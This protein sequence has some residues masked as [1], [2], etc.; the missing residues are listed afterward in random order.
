MFYKTI[1]SLNPSLTLDY[2]SNPSILESNTNPKESLNTHIANTLKTNT[3]IISNNI[4][5]LRINRANNTSNPNPLSNTPSITLEG[6]NII[7]AGI[8]DT[9][10]SYS[11]K[12]SSSFFG[13]KKSSF[14]ESS[15]IEQAKYSLI[16]SDS[17]LTL[18]A[19]SSLLL[20]GVKISSNTFS[21]AHLRAHE[22]DSYL[23]CRLLLEKK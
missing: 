3:S 9:T 5:T 7:Q 4:N 1:Y 11:H 22:T 21:Y 12:T 23:V 13:L 15:F 17:N 6:N 10:F 20:E 18:D 8:K 2:N 14:K 19:T 16:Q